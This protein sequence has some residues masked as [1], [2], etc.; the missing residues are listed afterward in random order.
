[1]EKGCTVFVTLQTL[2]WAAQAFGKR[3]HIE[4]V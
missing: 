1:M 4:L 3:L 2:G